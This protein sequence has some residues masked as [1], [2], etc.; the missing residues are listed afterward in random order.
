MPGL[1]DGLRN[2]AVCPL[3]GDPH[4]QP[5]ARIPEPE[6]KEIGYSFV[7]EVSMMRPRC[8]I[9]PPAK[10]MMNSIST[11]RFAQSLTCSISS[12]TADGLLNN[13]LGFGGR[14]FH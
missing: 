13:P 5:P 4:I 6:A 8:V 1:W 12:L 14:R 3:Y 7:S 10:G 2:L 9:E 11:F